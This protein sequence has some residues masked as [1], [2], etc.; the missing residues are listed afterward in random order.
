MN[1]L[2][3]SVPDAIL[4]CSAGMS[5]VLG[6][7]FVES[8]LQLPEGGYL[9]AVLPAWL[10][11][12][13]LWSPVLTIAAVCFSPWRWMLERSPRGVRLIAERAALLAFP[14]TALFY[15]WLMAAA[16]RSAPISFHVMSW[17]ISWGL[18]LIGRRIA[19]GVAFAVLIGGGGLLLVR[20]YE[21]PMRA[22]KHA[23]P[24]APSVLLVVM[25]TARK[26]HFSLYRYGRRTTPFVD[27]VGRRGVV[28]ERAYSTGSWTKP[29][30]A[31]LVTGRHL[32]EDPV[33]DGAPPIR[34][35]G[36]FLAQYFRD[37]G[38]DTALF[39][40]NSNASSYF[41]HA[42]GYSYR[43]HSLPPPHAA[44]QR[45]TA[46]R[47]LERILSGETELQ[48]K[49]IELS[50][51]EF[52]RALEVPVAQLA[53]FA[54]GRFDSPLR[55]EA[56]EKAA[57][58]ARVRAMVEKQAITELRSFP[59]LAPARTGRWHSYAA[60]AY[61]FVLGFH[62]FLLQGARGRIVSHW[63]K[64][65]ELCDELLDWMRRRSD[66]P[67]PFLAHIQL[68]GPHT[69]Y[70]PQLPFLLPHFDRGFEPAVV[71][72]PTQ[73]TP[74]SVPAP[75]LPA[76]KLHN[77]ISNYDDSLRI[78]DANLRELFAALSR[79]G[80][81][82]NTIVVILSDH[83]E[84]FYEHGIYGHMNSLHAELVDIPLVFSFPGRLA[85][86]RTHLPAGITDV[87]PSLIHLAGLDS[88]RA[89]HDSGAWDGR[90]LFAGVEHFAVRSDSRSDFVLPQATLVGG[91]WKN[92]QARATAFGVHT[93][94]TTPEGKLIREQEEGAL[95]YFFFPG[96]GD[97]RE[98]RVPVEPKEASAV[99]RR[100]IQ[101]LPQGPRP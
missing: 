35:R 85:P 31:S 14:A 1:L 75:R 2:R 46:V 26:D 99:V 78:T 16:G 72:P 62:Y 27:E 76:R 36:D 15:H 63:I 24:G 74:P 51:D 97:S 95:R 73:H 64:D 71:A 8:R 33:H 7:V 53:A 21:R 41:G 77:L 59:K 48:L 87:F 93:A 49:N 100:L 20:A 54:Q 6:L 58:R 29:S 25:D 44:L 81:L 55:L 92:K 18:V 60:G 42:R 13:A 4:A 40:A 10:V 52:A 98:E 86:A 32:T 3:R 79:M 22:A 5:L 89:D 56:S 65:R 57:Y 66:D 80:A 90:S 47:Y 39:S 23:R 88:G 67:R 61:R 82:R 91:T 43:L 30:T 34:Y 38:Y 19:A 69:P 28:F 84:A 17:S 96:A 37:R 50:L 11:T 83:G 68:M 70:S 45:F 101:L 9:E 94:V 12:A